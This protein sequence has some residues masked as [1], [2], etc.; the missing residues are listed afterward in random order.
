[1]LSID[2]CEVMLFDTDKALHDSVK[3]CFECNEYGALFNHHKLYCSELS[4]VDRSH[5]VHR[6]KRL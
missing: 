6:C 3:K 1:M 4:E 5:I 2:R